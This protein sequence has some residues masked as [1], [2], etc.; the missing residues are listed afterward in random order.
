[1]VQSAEAAERSRLG[2]FS[3]SS[4]HQAR[5]FQPR[6]PAFWLYVV[7][8]ALTGIVA[9]AEQN[10]FREMSPGGW[11]PLLG[12][13]HP[14]C[15]AGRRARVSARSLRTRADPAV[16]RGVRLGRRSRHDPRLD[17]ERWVGELRCAS[18]RAGVRVPMDRG[19]QCAVRRGALKAL[20]IGL[21]VLIAR[22]ELDDVM[23]GF[24]WAPSLGSASSSSRTSSTSSPC[25]A[26]TSE[27]CSEGSSSV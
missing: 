7:V 10:L 1:M 14:L 5:F 16:D 19:D 20:G 26:A 15:R 18:R 17:R 8:V 23:D 11:V 9:I 2:L 24:V 25:S 3:R 21:I 6:V 13:R 12:A 27:V 4:L 22:D